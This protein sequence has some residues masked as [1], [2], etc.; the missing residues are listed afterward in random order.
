MTETDKENLRYIWKQ[1]RSR[2]LERYG[3]D[4]I[5][6]G[7]SLRQKAKDDFNWLSEHLGYDYHEVPKGHTEAFAKTEYQSKGM[8]KYINAIIEHFGTPENPTSFL[9]EVL[10]PEIKFPA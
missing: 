7:L 2:I 8:Q 5:T 3:Y 9:L 10:F 6:D 1:R 4:L